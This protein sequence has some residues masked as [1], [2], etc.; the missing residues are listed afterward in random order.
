MGTVFKRWHQGIRYGWETA[1]FLKHHA[2]PDQLLAREIHLKGNDQSCY[3]DNAGSDS[4][5]YPEIY[6][7]EYW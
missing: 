2:H 4:E 7:L 3:G 5:D 6:F 1:F